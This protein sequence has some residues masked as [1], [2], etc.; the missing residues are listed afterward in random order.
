[1]VGVVKGVGVENGVTLCDLRVFV[2]EAAESIASKDA[3]VVGGGGWSGFGESVRGPLSEGLV[4]P[5]LVVVLRV[6]IDD[7]A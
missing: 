3:S 4:W 2:D 7:E 6:L 1:M 5:V